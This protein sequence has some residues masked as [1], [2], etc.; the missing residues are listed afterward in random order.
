MCVYA[1]AHALLYRRTLTHK[2][3]LYI[4]R[5]RM[6]PARVP[7]LRARPLHRTAL[8][9]R[10]ATGRENHR[11]SALRYSGFLR[12]DEESA[13][14]GK[15]I[16][17]LR[18]SSG[19]RRRGE[20]LSLRERKRERYGDLTRSEDSGESGEEGWRVRAWPMGSPVM[21]A[22]STSEGESDVGRAR[23]RLGTPMYG[24]RDQRWR[25][26]SSANRAP[27]SQ[28]FYPAI[29]TEDGEDDSP[30]IVAS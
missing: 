2:R 12:Q 14:E 15:R 16:L 26:E 17:Y 1:R 4:Q 27:S 20:T 24:V 28:V 11:G 29:Y 18:L 8:H 9:G 19:T 21:P 10:S 6:S 25:P 3:G 30:L 22:F 7:C 5:P 13:K 23:R